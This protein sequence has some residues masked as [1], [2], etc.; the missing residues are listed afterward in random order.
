M[1]LF[2]SCLQNLRFDSLSIIAYAHTKLAIIVSNFSLDPTCPRMLKGVSQNLAR[3]QADFVARERTQDFSLTFHCQLEDWCISVRIQRAR[4][5]LTCGREP[6]RQVHLAPHRRAQMLN[7]TS[8]L[9]NGIFGRAE[10]VV[11][12]LRCLVRPARQHV[13]SSLKLN[14]QS[15]QILQ[16]GVM[17]FSRDAC[18]LVYTRLQTCGEL[19]LE[20]MQPELIERPEQSQKCGHTQNAEPSGLVVRRR[21]GEIQEC[22]GLVPHAAVVGGGHAKNVISRRQV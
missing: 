13:A 10:R 22:A 17:E 14:H 15:V 18:P 4:Q 8:T 20:L 5:F 2:A 9:G 1:S 6:L 16:Q 19:L 11:Q 12:N 21:D 7:S 3:N